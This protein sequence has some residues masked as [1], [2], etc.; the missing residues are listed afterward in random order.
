MTW[1]IGSAARVRSSGGGAT[2]VLPHI[3]MKEFPMA[4]SD[5]LSAI[6]SLSKKIGFTL[7]RRSSMSRSILAMLTF[8][9]VLSLGTQAAADERTDLMALIKTYREN[10]RAIEFKFESTA[11]RLRDDAFSQMTP[12]KATMTHLRFAG[13]RKYQDVTFLAD[14]HQPENRSIHVFDGTLTRL[15]YPSARTANIL[16]GPVEGPNFNLV[17]QNMMW[18][19]DEEGQKSPY[20]DVIA[21]IASK[22]SRVVPERQHL[23]G[24]EMTVVEIPSWLR[25]WIDVSNGGIVRQIEFLHE[26]SWQSRCQIPEL[27][28]VNGI[29]FPAVCIQESFTSHRNPKEM[30]DQVVWRIVHRI[31]P[32]SVRINQPLGAQAFDYV[33]PEGTTVV[34]VTKMT[35]AE[36][37]AMRENASKRAEEEARQWTGLDGL[38]GK[39]APA[40]STGAQWLHHEPLSWEKLRGQVVVLDFFA[41]W[42]GPCRDDLPFAS[43]LHRERQ[44]RGYIVI[45]IHTHSSKFPQIQKL[46]RDFDI[47]YPICID[48][49]ADGKHLWGKMF[50]EFKI[51]SIPQA[52]L[53]DE[54]GNVAAYGTLEAM[55]AK[56]ATMVK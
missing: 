25:V 52:V 8:I 34:D 45:G 28:V 48:A 13:R 5:H 29:A 38:I 50:G 46:V 20:N 7:K 23:F 55:A 51:F 43:Q 6:S 32:E 35:P 39:P 15:Y 42:C 16:K 18:A 30:W 12:A 36:M 31:H 24:S 33:F 49:T 1:G 3:C 54:N 44:Q 4:R 37:A 14:G 21:L 40:F 47:D 27:L 26:G 53:I 17:Y 11:T 22:D 10:I 19:Q 41:E 9:W 56:A 2:S